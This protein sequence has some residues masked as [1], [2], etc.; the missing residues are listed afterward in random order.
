MFRVKGVFKCNKFLLHYY[1]LHL[2]TLHISYVFRVL[3]FSLLCFISLHYYHFTFTFMLF[4]DLYKYLNC[5]ADKAIEASPTASTD[6][7]Y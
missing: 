3:Q 4:L 2:D 1:I 5:A 7:N 6:R